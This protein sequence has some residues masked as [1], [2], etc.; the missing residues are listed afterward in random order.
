MPSS[1]SVSDTTVA[2][3]K[4][5]TACDVSDALLRLGVPGAGFLPDLEPCS[6]G[7]SSDITIAPA[8]TM[9]FAPKGVA[10]DDSW[11]EKNISPDANWSDIS[12]PDTI[13]VLKQPVGQTNA[14]CGGIMALRMKVLGVKGIVAV[15]R[16]RDV[17]ELGSLGLP[18][19]A[20]SPP[21]RPVR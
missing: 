18:V 11:P 1:A 21:H 19:S 16:V 2:A 10:L 17:E 7:G 3:L 20:S 14:V 5:Y 15:G 12:E 8:S 4:K 13:A 6:P 9:L